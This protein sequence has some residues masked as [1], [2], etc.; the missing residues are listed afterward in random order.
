VFEPKVIAKHATQM[1]KPLQPIRPSVF[2]TRSSMDAVTKKPIVRRTA[3]SVTG[4]PAEGAVRMK[5]T[6][7]RKPFWVLAPDGS[8]IERNYDPEQEPLIVD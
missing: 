3:R 7:G 5:K 1:Q 4:S 2:A 8:T 6:L